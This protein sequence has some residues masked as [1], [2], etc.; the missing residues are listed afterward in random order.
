MRPSSQSPMSDWHEPDDFVQHLEHLARTRPRDTA[1]IVVRAEQGDT[2]ETRLD[3]DTFARRAR[4]IAATLQQRF[5]PGD[6]VLIM[7]DNDEHY[8]A[9]LFGCFY[10]G[11]IAVPVFPPESMRLQHLTRLESIARDASAQGV[12]TVSALLPLVIEGAH[13]FGIQTVLAIDKIDPFEAGRWQPRHPRLEEIAFLQYTSGSTG[14]PKGVMVT[15]G[16]LM[17]NER[18]IKTVLSIGPDDSFGVWAPLFHDMGLIGGLLQPVYSGI[19]CV[20]ASP[21]FFL[22]NPLR[23]LQMISRHRISLSGGPDFAFRLCLDRIKDSQ[24][25]DLNLSCWRL[26]YTGAEPVRSDTMAAFIERFSA[27]GFRG[28]AVYPCYGLAEATLLVTG[29]QRGAGMKTVGFDGLAL[30][31]RQVRTKPDGVVQVG[32]GAI[33]PEHQLGL[34]TSD[35][36]AWVAP[37]QIG[38]IWVAG[39]SIAA[40]YWNNPEATAA[41]FVERDG[42]RWLRTGDLGFLHEGQLYI[43]GR[44]KDMIIVRGHNLFPQDIERVVEEEVEAVRK[45]RCAAFAVDVEGSEG[46]GVAAEISRGLQKLIAPATLIQAIKV[47]VSEAFG[48][49]PATVVLLNPGALP[50]TSS[51]K[52]QR[53]ACQQ[54]WLAG[55]LDTYAS[56]VA[57]R[58]RLAD[59]DEKPVDLDGT[60]DDDGPGGGGNPVGGASPAS[61]GE[62]RNE[63]RQDLSTDRVRL[64]ALWQE[65]LRHSADT[66]YHDDAHFLAEG[67]NSLAAT[68]LAAR[69]AQAWQLDISL[70][71]VTEAPRF[72]QQLGLIRQARKLA[73]EHPS[74]RIPLLDE[75]SRYQPQP[76]TAA[77][78]QQWFLWRMNPSSSAYHIQG[79][80]RL[81]GL[82]DI[83]LLE[84]AVQQLVSRHSILQTVFQSTADGEVMQ[85]IQPGAIPVLERHQLDRLP[86]IDRQHRALDILKARNLEPFDLEQGPLFR[87]IVIRLSAQTHVLGL[88]L[89]HIIADGSSV[90]ILLDELGAIHA[91][92]SA[93]QAPTEAGKSVASVPYSDY[94]AWQATPEAQAGLA[95]E[96]LYWEAQLGVAGGVAQPVLMLPTDHPRP[97]VAT[98]RAG[99]VVQP[100]P[101]ALKGALDALAQRLG[102]SRFVLMLAAF[103]ALLNR[104]TAQSD[105]RV[106]V[107]VANRPNLAVSRTIGLFVN[108]VVVRGQLDGRE[109]WQTLIRQLN[110][111][112]LA[113]QAHQR[114][115]FE[116]LVERL[117]PQRD[118][119]HSPL[120]QVMFNQLALDFRGLGEAL[121]VRVQEI[122][123][124]PE[125]AQFELSL[126]VIDE[127]GGDTR[128]R[129]THARELFDTVT[130]ERLAAHYLRLLQA[131]T[132]NPAQALGEAPMLAETDRSSLQG[133]GTNDDLAS[134]GA[135]PVH[136]LFEEQVQQGAQ[137]EALVFGAQTLSYEQVNQCANQLAH[138]LVRL[139]VGPEVRVGIALERSVEMVVGLLA[140]LKAGGAYVPLDPEYPAERLRYMIE[141]SGIGLL[142]THTAV[143]PKLD[144]LGLN[145]GV[146]SGNAASTDCPA[147]DVA[148]SLRADETGHG[149]GDATTAL[150]VLNLDA[151]DVS[152][153]PVSNPAVAV[154][155]ENLAY[156]IYTSGSTGKPKGA[157]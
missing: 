117:A 53:S 28:D 21:R 111:T 152:Q 10:S 101:H 41:T 3:Y 39:P 155:G 87:L 63:R 66:V 33:A 77:Q 124:A 134:E 26:A 45:G 11:V 15:H 121:K 103:Q 38:E 79:A 8:A 97:A 84:R 130:I 74:S 5:Q 135:L 65:A 132:E 136:S 144:E 44:Q 113:A 75:A 123:I 51:G 106:G 88:I 92:L 80:L 14:N 2:V 60:P 148:V 140:I 128:L 138:H 105:I 142:L 19:P 27:Y 146:V 99:Q 141:D 42:Q 108:T 30:A 125:H 37:D 56:E 112:V 52:V 18:A 62:G 71:E 4:A 116:Q 139:G 143:Q 95:E 70:R 154:H 151:V 115:P 96:A 129:F 107:P 91:G 72:G 153:Y 133:W 6:R 90:Q 156:V 118:L 36:Q 50:K 24:C 59:A 1:L 54:G 157:A 109:S 47:A 58:F 93:G 34:A 49:S 61:K 82:I 12:L 9:S 32:C 86:I 64:T 149:W 89:H 104:Y 119:A 40:G 67:G 7:M 78:K 145:I 127:L 85:Q 150:R 46:I 120:F 147:G 76:L 23:W 73:K 83:N 13:Q 102:C 68:L 110:D 114:H 16:N 81:D 98:Y 22:E 55:S 131:M 69:M 122:P 25:A 57:G 20:L 31:Q 29:G 100:L 17:A 94:A 35:G 43:S 48:E 137:W 126:D